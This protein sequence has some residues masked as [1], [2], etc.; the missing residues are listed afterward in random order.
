M[1]NFYPYLQGLLLLCFFANPQQN[2]IQA[3]VHEPNVFNKRYYTWIKLLDQKR[4]VKGYLIAIRDSSILLQKNIASSRTL[5]IEEYPIDNIARISF[6]RRHTDIIGLFLGGLLG[7]GVGAGVGFTVEEADYE[8]LVNIFAITAISSI[9]GMIVGTALGGKRKR[10][11]L[12]GDIET[13]SNYRTA[14]VRY[15]YYP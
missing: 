10:F 5:D 3:Q 14:F 9:P 6:R 4:Q 8:G 11:T 7:L 12:N 1:K 15:L 13:Y 2:Q